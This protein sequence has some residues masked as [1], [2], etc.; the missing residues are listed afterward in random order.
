MATKQ[1]KLKIATPEKIILEEDVDS[2]TVPT[3][4]GEI[5]IL[6]GHV[7]L[8]SA[9]TKGDIV[10]TQGADVIPMAVVGGFVQVREDNEVV[11]LADFAEHVSELSEDQIADAKKKAE[12]AL[13]DSERLSKEEFEFFEGQLERALVA[14]KIHGKWKTKK[15]KKI[16][17]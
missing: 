10:A 3:E 1:I 8:V 17:I 5:G 13:S 4:T 9:L 12:E 7:P 14:S 6:S 2:L 11:I 16:S 15:Y